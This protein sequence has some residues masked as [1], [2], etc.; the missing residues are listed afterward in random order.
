MM[1]NSFISSDAEREVFRYLA[2]ANKQSE[3]IWEKYLKYVFGGFGAST[4]LSYSSSWLGL[5]SM[6]E[7]FDTEN[8]YK[9]FKISY[10]L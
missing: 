4:V 1:L 2:R 6:K 3:I 5:I 10:V 9:Q 7:D 8:L